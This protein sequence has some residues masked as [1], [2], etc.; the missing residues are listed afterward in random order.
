MSY[1]SIEQEET[2]SYYKWISI[3]AALVGGTFTAIR[4]F[5]AKHV[6]VHYNYSPIDFSIDSGIVIGIFLFLS[7]SFF[8]LTGT[9]PETYD[10]RNFVICLFSSHLQM[11]TSLVGLNCTVKGLAGPT[12][13]IFQAQSLVS[14]MLNIVFFSMVPTLNQVLAAVLTVSGVLTIISAN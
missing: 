9:E 11:L 6:L 12:S 5:Q 14:I 7:A 3:I 4:I 2:H 8:Y 10:S 1:T 13:A